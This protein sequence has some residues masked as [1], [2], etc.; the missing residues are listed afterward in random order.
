M[1]STCVNYFITLH[2]YAEYRIPRNAQLKSK[3]TYLQMQISLKSVLL[4]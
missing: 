1:I 2:S 4:N 3:E